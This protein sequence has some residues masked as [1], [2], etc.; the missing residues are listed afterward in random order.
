MDVCFAFILDF[1]FDT[2]LS[3]LPFLI[4]TTFALCNVDGNVTPDQ[5]GQVRYTNRPSV[6]AL[7]AYH[8][9]EESKE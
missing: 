4:S 3:S 9:I 8:F 6:D 5:Q 1:K 2:F 7:F